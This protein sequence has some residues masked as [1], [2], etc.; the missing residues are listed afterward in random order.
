MQASRV[1]VCFLLVARDV[2]RCGS[3]HEATASGDVAIAWCAS[4]SRG[5]S[6]R[7]TSSTD[8]SASIDRGHPWRATQLFA[9]VLR[10]PQKRTPAALLVAARAAA[11]WDGWAEVDKLLAAETWIDT[12]FDG[13][14]R[15]LL[16]AR[17]LERG[18]DTSRSRMRRRQ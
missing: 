4:S 18:A 5:R 9:P 6:R 11:G 16:T 10:D 3:S 13:E 2:R 15:E 1:V 17:R 12:Q 14:A 7:A 8:A